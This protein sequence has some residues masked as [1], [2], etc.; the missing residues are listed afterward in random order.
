[1]LGPLIDTII[2]CSI[3]AFSILCT[4]VWENNTLNGIEMTSEAFQIGIPIIGEK[5]LLIIVCI[6]SITTIIGYSYYGSKCVGFLF[7]TKWK[8]TYRALYTLSMIPAAII[9]I[10]VV[11]NYVDSMF[12]IMAIPTMISTI[13]LSPKVVCAAKIYFSKLC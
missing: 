5:I 2:V 1:M 9:S 8:T 3:T 12:A 7:G 10:D 11:V 13:L 4:G 6:F